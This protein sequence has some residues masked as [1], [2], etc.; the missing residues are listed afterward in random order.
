LVLRKL[1]RDSEVFKDLDRRT[2]NIVIEGIAEARAH[3]QDTFRNG[4]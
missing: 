1:D 2:G 4:A 3:Q